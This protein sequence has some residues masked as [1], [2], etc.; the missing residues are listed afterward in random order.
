LHVAVIVSTIEDILL[1]QAANDMEATSF[2]A[3]VT[4][5]KTVELYKFDFDQFEIKYRK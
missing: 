4:V 2:P 5:S 3:N 1:S